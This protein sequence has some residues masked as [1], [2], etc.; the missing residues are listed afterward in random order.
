MPTQTG[1]SL[2][3]GD[4]NG[5]FQEYRIRRA[6]ERVINCRVSDVADVDDE[7]GDLVGGAT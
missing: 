5:G 2:D 1:E 3:G 4:S 6:D 7:L